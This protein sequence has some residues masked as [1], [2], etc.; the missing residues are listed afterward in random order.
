MFLGFKDTIK[1]ILK[2]C[3]IHHI[4]KRVASSRLESSMYATVYYMPWYKI[5]M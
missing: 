5:V 2:T 1:D 3:G 4:W